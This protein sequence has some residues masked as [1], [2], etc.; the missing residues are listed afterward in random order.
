DEVKIRITDPQSLATRVKRRTDALRPMIGIPELRG[1]EDIF[2]G[3]SSGG[4][5]R[6]Q[7]LA[8]LAFVSIAFRAIEMAKADLQ[9][10]RGGGTSLG[11]VRD[12]SSETQRRH[13]TGSGVKGHFCNSK[14]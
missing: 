6:L 5:L 10:V 11:R 1:D 9:R 4:D 13:G 14:V 12:Q 7:R 3:E 2:A 8:H